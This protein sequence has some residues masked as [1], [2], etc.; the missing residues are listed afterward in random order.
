MYIII[1]SFTSS[2][3]S[4]SYSLAS[5]PLFFLLGP[6]SLPFTSPSLYPYPYLS[7]SQQL[8][9]FLSHYLQCVDFIFR[10]LTSFSPSSCVLKKMATGNSRRALRIIPRAYDSRR[11][12]KKVLSTATS[13]SF[14]KILIVSV[15]QT[16]LCP[17]ENFTDWTA[18][19][20]RQNM[21]NLARLMSKALKE[22]QSRQKC[23]RNP[24]N[25]YKFLNH[26]V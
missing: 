16:R 18:C 12:N 19:V 5:P 4:F 8:S 11:K 21:V 23:N 13:I 26:S 20:G 2:P 10:W 7:S 9:L 17:D 3:S 25:H 1:S 22:F 14:L 24:N 6:L 15:L